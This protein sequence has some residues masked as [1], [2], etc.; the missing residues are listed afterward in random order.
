V[1]NV[2]NELSGKDVPV[3]GTSVEENASAGRE[4]VGVA[5]AGIM[6][7]VATAGETVGVAEC[8]ESQA[9][10]VKD[11]TTRVSNTGAIC[12]PIII[13]ASLFSLFSLP[14]IDAHYY[15]AAFPDDA[16][17]DERDFSRT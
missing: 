7:G 8:G 4:T 10:R 15:T 13:L 3:G 5:A 16:E 14:I 17:S 11:K 6:V 9:E 12:L 2:S 1:G